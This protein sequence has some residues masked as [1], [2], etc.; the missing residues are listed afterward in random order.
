MDRLA[1]AALAA[2]ALVSTTALAFAQNDTP[3][4]V[5]RPAGAAGSC[6][7]VLQDLSARMREDGLWLTGWNRRDGSLANGGM[8]PTLD[9]VVEADDT[10]AA[11]PETGAPGRDPAG[12]PV[13]IGEAAGPW[14]ERAW[15][16]APR[17]ELRALFNA[18]HVL[19]RQGAEEACLTV[20]GAATDLYGRFTGEFGGD[21]DPAAISAWR[22]EQLRGSYPMD[23]IAGTVSTGEIVGAD[24]RNSKDDE[25][26]E[27]EDLV[28]D[29]GSGRILY[30][31]IERDGFWGLGEDTVAVPFAALRTTPT[32]N[33]FVLPVPEAVMDEAPLLDDV[34]ET[35]SLAAVDAYWSEAIG[36]N[37]I[38]AAPQ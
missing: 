32:L 2:S 31:L 6:L 19:A 35:G 4:E 33:M 28:F 25:L 30:A 37:R 13:A 21:F 8:A 12:E 9:Q 34:E 16:E 23:Q 11:D 26:G 1:T 24:V 27:I 15:A 7:E 36:G 10:V 22:E 5:Q 3:M 20:A 14:G 38:P 29:P 18:A 17:R